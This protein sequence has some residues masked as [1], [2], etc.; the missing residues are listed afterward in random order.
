MIHSVSELSYWLVALGTLVEGEVSLALA[1]VAAERG[2]MILG[3]VIV[4]AFAG[5]FVGDQ[6]TFIVLRWLGSQAFER[7]PSLATR[8]SRVRSILARRAVPAIFITRFLW[9][10]RMASYAT[11][12]NSGV[13]YPVFFVVNAISCAAWAT[14]VGGLAFAFSQS[15]AAVIA[16]MQEA[17]AIGL[18][19]A[20][21][22]VGG[23]LVI[24]LIRWL[25]ARLLAAH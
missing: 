25:A 7:F 5:A 1:A 22:L 21:F 15:V 9:G 18:E 20:G 4:F 8:T 13:R 23:A 24:L 16:R 6:A 12:A 19:A 11:L 17:Q 10:M 14:A 2:L 3:W